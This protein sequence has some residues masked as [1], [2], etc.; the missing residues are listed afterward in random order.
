MFT[1]NP[2]PGSPG[3]ALIPASDWEHVGVTLRLSPRELQIVQGVFNDRKDQTIAG[4]LG[5]SP[6]TVKTYF[7]RLYAKL[8]VG[9][10]SQLIVCVMAEYLASAPSLHAGAGGQPTGRDPA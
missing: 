8:R 10:R 7:Q 6:H 2:V 5:I 4:D 3:H 9:S 1:R